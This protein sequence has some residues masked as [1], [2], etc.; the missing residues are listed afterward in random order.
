MRTYFSINSLADKV[1]RLILLALTTVLCLPF[2]GLAQT[3]PLGCVVNAGIDPQEVCRLDHIQL[4]GSPTVNETLIAELQS[5]EWTVLSGSNVEFMSSTSDENP[6]VQIEET[7]VFQ[8]TLTLTDGSVCLDSITLVPIVEPT[9]RPSRKLG[10][11]R[12]KHV[13]DFLQHLA[14]QQRG[15][16]VRCGLGGWSN[17][18][19]PAFRLGVR[20]HLR[21]GRRLQCRGVRLTRELRERRNCGRV[22]RHSCRRGGTCGA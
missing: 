14:F 13:I 2:S 18:R 3:D 16:H 4:G 8:V 9:L 1:L 21:S 11:V 7:S 10:A 6:M 17:N 12:W 22:P 15:H 19:R 5:L 20:T